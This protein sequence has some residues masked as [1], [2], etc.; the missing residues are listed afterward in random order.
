[1]SAFRDEPSLDEPPGGPSAVLLDPDQE[2][3][4]VGG[5]LVMGVAP[6]GDDLGDAAP[7][8]GRIDVRKAVGELDRLTH[9]RQCSTGNHGVACE[10]KLPLSSGAPVGLP[11]AVVGRIVGIPHLTSFP[12][13]E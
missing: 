11:D 2:P 1:M 3:W 12:Q 5:R 10:N 13:W 8:L 9:R 6:C 7:A 4:P